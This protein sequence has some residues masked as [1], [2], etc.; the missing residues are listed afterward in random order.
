MA[1]TLVS[2]RLCPF[3]DWP[4]AEVPRAAAGVYTI[5]DRGGALVYVGISG[6]GLSAE[7]LTAAAA[8]GKRVGLWNRLNSHASGRRSG[9]QFC[10]YVC[11]RLV[12]PTLTTD[13]IAR[14]AAGEGSLDAL[15]RAYVRT[16]LG[17]RYATTSDGT[18]ALE[19]EHRVRSGEL[20]P[21]PL[22]NPAASEK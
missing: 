10:V 3:A 16:H 19:L 6:R 8:D 7:Q 5:W 12:L 4:V 1:E 9:D 21:L 11:D 2:G 22:L 15:T 18:M 20:G 17:F 14:V 13:D